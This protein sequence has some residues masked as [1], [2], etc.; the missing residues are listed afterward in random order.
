MLILNFFFGRLGFCGE[1]ILFFFLFLS[2]SRAEARLG[3]RFIQVVL[4]IVFGHM[5]RSNSIE[6]FTVPWIC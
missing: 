2:K 4:W 1:D 6:E 3:Q 5:V